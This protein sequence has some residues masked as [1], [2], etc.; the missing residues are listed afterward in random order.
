MGI[1]SEPYFTP[2]G[3]PIE[4]KVGTAKRIK[5]FLGFGA[6]FGEKLER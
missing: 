1:F 5:N 4:P 3:N 2:T 6:R